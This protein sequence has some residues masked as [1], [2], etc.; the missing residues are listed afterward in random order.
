MSVA[1]RHSYITAFTAFAAD[2][3]LNA[4]VVLSAPRAQPIA[5]PSTEDLIRKFA[6]VEQAA[7]K[8][9]E[10]QLETL[11]TPATF[12]VK[13]SVPTPAAALEQNFE[14]LEKDMAK[15]L[16][17]AS[18]LD[19]LWAKAGALAIANTKLWIIII[20]IIMIV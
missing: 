2:T 4:R 20:I 17:D 18:Q 13:A 9:R 19:A 3:N 6:A 14:R 5:N 11:K 10:S 16:A 7:A 8:K 12:T 15:L 1:P